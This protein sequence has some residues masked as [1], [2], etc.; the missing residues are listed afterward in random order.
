V[1]FI[2]I[3]GYNFDIM[4]GLELYQEDRPWGYFRQFCK[5]TPVTVKI[6]VIKAEEALSLQSHAKRSEFWRVVVGS[7]EAEI[8]GNSQPI[9]VGDELMISAG[10]KHRLSAGVYGLEI[11]EISFGEFD[12]NDITRYDDKYGRA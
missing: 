8:G 12:E 11:L 2:G 7:G 10:V 9:G 5:D 1:V 4:L 3:L 6:I